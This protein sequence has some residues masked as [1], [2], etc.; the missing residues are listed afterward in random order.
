M[1]AVDSRARKKPIDR[2]PA[3]LHGRRLEWLQRTRLYFV[4]DTEPGGN[5]LEEVLRSGLKNG[6]DIAQLRD[7]NARESELVAAGR[8]F[9]RLCDAYDALFIVNDRPDLALACAADGLHLGQD[10]MP[11]E[12]AREI[13]GPD[14]II[15]LSTHSTEQ[16]RAAEGCDY[17]SVG[18]VFETPT[19]PDYEAVGLELVRMAAEQVDIPFF[20]IGGIDDKNISQVLEAGAERVA[21]VRA[22]AE[23]PKPDEAAKKLHTLIDRTIES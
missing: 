6:V 11:V 1:S 16:I 15:G 14:L 5:D 8:V 18:P 19:K 12:E 20:A 17:L 23:A 3:S 4:C 21:V 7:K 13:V 22:I 2:N 10:D 9:R